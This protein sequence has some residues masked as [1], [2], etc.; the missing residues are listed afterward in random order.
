[1]LFGGRR[2]NLIPLVYQ[3]FNWQHGV[4][5]G[6]TMAS[7]TTAA[8]TGAVGV[9]RRDPMAMLP[10]CGY[11]MGDYFQHWLR[12]GQRLS[13][14]PMVFRVNWFRMNAEGKFLWPGFGENLRVLRWVLGRVHGE[15]GA[16]ET[17]IGYVPYPTGID[18]TGLDVSPEALQELFAIDRDGWLEA[19]K[20]QQELFKTFGNRLPRELW[21]ESEA[22]AQRLQA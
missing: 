19:V 22:L 21:Q 15:I 9:V 12:I 13:Q 1:M 17:P 14:P 8:A 4:F 5:L 20:G 2:A 16:A 11:N 3:S 6:A 10:F 7:E 18:V